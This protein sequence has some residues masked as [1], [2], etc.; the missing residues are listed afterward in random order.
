MSLD[1]TVTD[2]SRDVPSELLDRTAFARLRGALAAYD[3]AIAE[4]QA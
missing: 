2:L 1:I 4:G 3:A